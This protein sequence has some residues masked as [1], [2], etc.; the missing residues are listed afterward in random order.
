MKK[1]MFLF[2][3][4]LTQQLSAQIKQQNI[5]SGIWPGYGI[6]SQETCF[7]EAPCSYIVIDTSSHDNIWQSGTPAKSYFSSAY[8]A[9]QAMVTDTLNTYPVNNDSY[10]E[11]CIPILNTLFT[12]NT[13]ISFQHKFNSDT[14]K[15]GGYIKVQYFKDS[16]WRNIAHDTLAASNAVFFNCENLYGVHDTLYNGQAGFSGSSD[17]VETKLQWIWMLPVKDEYYPDTI[18]LR[19]HFISDDINN[20]KDGWMID[21]LEIDALDLGGSIGEFADNTHITAMPNPSQ[22][23][24]SVSISTKNTGNFFAELFDMF[25][26]KVSEYSGIRNNSFIIYRGHL[27]SGVYFLV[28]KNG[29]K[30]VAVKKII[31][32]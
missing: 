8:S 30:I 7:F 18:R 28:L 17:W 14:M 21:N 25:G 2:L 16:A 32:E 6:I 22:D 19:F 24:I 3:L 23:K 11:L 27:N 20:N 26:R 13:M 10:F 9:P 12:M 1:T 4:I 15:D 29:N 31:F 5:C